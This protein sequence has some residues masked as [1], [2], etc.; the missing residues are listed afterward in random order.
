MNELQEYNLGEVNFFS[1]P[2]LD[3]MDFVEHAFGTRDSYPL[4][5]SQQFLGKEIQNSNLLSMLFKGKKLSSSMFESYCKSFIHLKQIHSSKVISTSEI[6]KGSSNIA[7]AVISNESAKVLFLERT[8]RPIP[9]GS[10]V[11]RNMV[12]P[13]DT[14]FIGGASAPIKWPIE[15]PVII[16]RVMIVKTLITAV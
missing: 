9:T 16:G 4:N 12:S 7:D 2:L 1:S 11:I 8:M 3:S 5:H 6:K 15:N 13:N 10:A 14:R